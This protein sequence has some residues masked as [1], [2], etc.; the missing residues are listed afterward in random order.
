[1]K[2][3]EDLILNQVKKRRRKTKTKAVAFECGADLRFK[4]NHLVILY[5]DSFVLIPREMSLSKPTTAYN[6]YNQNQEK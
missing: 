2:L 5:Y 4:P 3:N 1:M 6:L